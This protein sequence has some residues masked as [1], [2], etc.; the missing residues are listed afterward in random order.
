MN[1]NQAVASV[2]RACV[3]QKISISDF[4]YSPVPLVINLC[5]E[6]STGLCCC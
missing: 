4:R 1:I 5:G 6:P 3:W 2:M